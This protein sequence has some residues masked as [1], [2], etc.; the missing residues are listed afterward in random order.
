LGLNKIDMTNKIEITDVTYID[1]VSVLNEK[2]NIKALSVDGVVKDLEGNNIILPDDFEVKRQELITEYNA[3]SYQRKRKLEY[4]P[5]TDY[6][7]AIVKGDQAQI[8]EYIAKCL[9]VKTKYPKP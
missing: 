5:V 1:D 8:D 6:L 2:Y 4:P 9:A 3:L 7:D